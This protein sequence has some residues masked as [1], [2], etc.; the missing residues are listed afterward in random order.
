ML[1]RTRDSSCRCLKGL[2]HAA[3]KG[4]INLAFLTEVDVLCGGCG[5][6][7]F[8]WFFSLKSSTFAV[9]VAFLWG[10]AAPET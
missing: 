1:G 2:G 8:C 9:S 5:F 7:F 4:S 6:D 10:S 3:E